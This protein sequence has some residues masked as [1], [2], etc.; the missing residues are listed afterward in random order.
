MF[1]INK[2]ISCRNKLEEG[3]VFY[4]IDED[5]YYLHTKKGNIKLEDYKMD[6]VFEMIEKFKD[7]SDNQ[8]VIT[9]LNELKD[10]LVKLHE[11]V[12]S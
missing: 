6:N 2:E 8:E 11:V 12:N 3:E 9:K 4:L 10:A 1:K 7:E 5:E